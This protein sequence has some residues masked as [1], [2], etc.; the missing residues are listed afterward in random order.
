V[1]DDATGALDDESER[2]IVETNGPRSICCRGTVIWSRE[3]M[4]R[5]AIG[6]APSPP[7]CAAGWEAEIVGRL[8]SGRRNRSAAAPER[9]GGGRR[10]TRAWR[11]GTS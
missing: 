7:R 11:S 4:R 9:S 10:A 6:P 3:G 8:G 1:V 2:I 5:A